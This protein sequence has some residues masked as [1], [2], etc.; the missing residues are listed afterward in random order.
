MATIEKLIGWRTKG[1]IE[2]GCDSD[3]A[4]KGVKKWLKENHTTRE[5]LGG[6]NADILRDIRA[7]MRRL[8]ET[9]VIWVKLKARRKREAQS[10]HELIND[11]TNTLNNMLHRDHK[12][13]SH[14]S[15]QHFS[16]ALAGLKIWNTFG[17]ITWITGNAGKSLQ[18][19]N[20]ATEMVNKQTSAY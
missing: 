13:Q 19:V 6:V 5:I 18:R 14:A 17:G 16:S 20:T 9:M 8:P 15:A 3:A 2:A 7:V 1:T 12:W 10:F 4:L 11:E